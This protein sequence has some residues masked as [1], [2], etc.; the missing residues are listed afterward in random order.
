[1]PDPDLFEQAT[2]WEAVDPDPIT[3]GQLRDLIADDD[4][5]ALAELF[6]GRL[7]FGTAG[8]RGAQGPGPNRMNRVTVRRMAAG[9]ADYL[10]P[11]TRVVIGYDARHNSDVFAQDAAEML[12]SRGVHASVIEGPVP[13]PVLAHRTGSS[14]ADLGLMV[15]DSHNPPADNGCKVFLADGAQLRTPTD[16]GI[17]AA[18][19]S[20][21][22]PPVDIP[23]PPAGV[24]ITRL[25]PEI[26]SDYVDAIVGAVEVSAGLACR[27]AYTPLHGVGRDTLLAVF[28]AA[29]APAPFVAGSQSDPDPDF[30][31]V[32]FPNPEEPGAM[33]AVVALARETSAQIAVANDP[34]ADRLA[35]AVPV[36]DGS[37]R[38]LT[39]DE[40]GAL[41]LDH[42][43]ARASGAPAK[44]VSTVVCSSLVGV[45]A[46]AAGLTHRVTL[47]GFKWIMAEAWADPESPPLLAYEES[48][49]YAAAAPVRDKDG[50]SAALLFVEMVHCLAQQGLTPAQR[51]DELAVQHGLHVTLQFSV[52]F[53]GADAVARA[54]AA[55]DKLR[56][57]PPEEIAGIAVESIIDY[58]GGGELPPTNLVRLDLA[59]GLR[60]L[61]RPSGTEPKTKLYLE[62]VAE[63]ATPDEARVQRPLTLAALEALAPALEELLLS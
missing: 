62:Q 60:V 31:T 37:W 21:G 40:V 22:V 34:D 25:G 63:V 16:A 54:G 9:V 45:M 18:I 4:G 41:L 19:D 39:G 29:G 35:V 5:D 13:T 42:L 33:D 36:S 8:I 10:G 12:A 1:M 2:A 50:I 38:S 48:L 11:G 58:A 3:R 7:E 44:V 47:T 30:P 49:G 32:S 24:E 53:E 56:L 23:S 43:L 46:Q 6:G 26:V 20:V 52:R 55:V 28:D 14:N 17:E 27:W 51:L 59:G 61:V 15:T 57:D